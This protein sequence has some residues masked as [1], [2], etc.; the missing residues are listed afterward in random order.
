MTNSCDAP[1]SR[2]S[3]TSHPRDTISG[4]API[5]GSVSVLDSKPFRRPEG[6]D[7]VTGSTQRQPALLCRLSL[8]RRLA[9]VAIRPTRHGGVMPLTVRALNS[10]T[11]SA[12]RMAALEVES[13]ARSMM[14]PPMLV[15]GTIPMVSGVDISDRGGVKLDHLALPRATA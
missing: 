5:R 13:R 7:Y 2:T 14:W 15:A 3:R 10:A 11:R 8:T 6:R 4:T 12:Q 9:P 1:R